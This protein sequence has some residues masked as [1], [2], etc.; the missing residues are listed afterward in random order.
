MEFAIKVN[1]N[2]HGA[3]YGL[4]QESRQKPIQKACQFMCQEKQ[5][6]VLNHFGTVVCVDKTSVNSATKTLVN[7]IAKMITLFWRN[8]VFGEVFNTHRRCS[9]AKIG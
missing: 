9:F 3:C 6:A 1:T 5:I 2:N 7:S 8:F 4:C